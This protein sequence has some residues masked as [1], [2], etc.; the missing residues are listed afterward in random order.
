[1]TM[2]TLPLAIIGTLAPFAPL[3]SARVWQHAQVL[4]AGAI[5]GPAQRTVAAA[6][7]VVGLGQ[8]RQFHRY[9]RVLSRDRWSG[10]AVSRVLL[11]LLVA[12]FV[13]AGP[14]VFGIDETLE[15]RRGT[16]I[17]AKGIYRDA[18][19]S[20]HSHFVKAS[21]LRWVCL[22]LLV[23]I[24]WA[25]RIWAL[26]VLTALAPSERYHQARRQRHK[27]LLDWGR[28]MLLVVRR[29]WPDRTL[30]AVADSSY[31]ALDFLAACQSWRT[32]VSVITRLRL[33]AALYTPA[34]PRRAGQLGRP[35]RKGKRLP[36]LAAVAADPTT[37]WARVTVAQWYG[38]G[39]RTVE[40]ASDTA[41][42]YHSGL[43][44]V[45]IHWVLIRDPQGQFETQA[46]LCTDLDVRPAQILT[47]FVQRWQLEVTFEEAR[48]H[49]G[50]ETQRQWS[51]R[52]IRRTTPVLLGLFSLITLLA[53]QSMT[54]S[55]IVPRQAA[56]YHKPLPTF[57]DALAVV[58]RDLW[59]QQTFSTSATCGDLVKVPHLVLER[60]TETLSY[61]A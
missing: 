6:L 24:P 52:A 17:A 45:P 58:R 39:E 19:R 54:V 16:N 50:L 9:H 22:M 7:R 30:I 11:H 8:T 57:A 23:P 56:W 28:Q 10:L 53:H 13:P 42:W 51:E 14:L 41:V 5:L 38:V 35:R 36:T 31:A 1:M 32:P 47:W 29:W 55:P 61:V 12:A 59:R 21:G 26:P 2:P 46:L 4:L 27:M 43:P 49:L 33:D 34:P 60:L 25:A 3:F 40:V 15:R 37:T 18:V 44:A 48:R 20:S